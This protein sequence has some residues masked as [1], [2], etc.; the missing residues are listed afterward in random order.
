[1]SSLLKKERSKIR[2]ITDML[3]MIEKGTTGGI[4]HAIHRYRKENNKYMINYD[5]SKESLF[6][7][8]FVWMGSCFKNCLYMVLSGKKYV[9]M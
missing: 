6:I 9:K 2:I 8:Q 4:S 5:K 1:M 7:I 3:L